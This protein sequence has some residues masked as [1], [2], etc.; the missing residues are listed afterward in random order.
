MSLKLL[1]AW[2]LLIAMSAIITGETNA[3][4]SDQKKFE[5]MMQ[6][7]NWEQKKKLIVRIK[8][9]NTVIGIVAH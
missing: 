5:V 7:G 1:A 3:Y 9:K 4:F 6:A 8:M 2:Y